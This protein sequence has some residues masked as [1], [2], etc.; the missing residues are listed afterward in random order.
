MERAKFK[1]FS[2]LYLDNPVVLYCVPMVEPRRLYLK[3]SS[4]HQHQGGVGV[5]THTHTLP[6]CIQKMKLGRETEKEISEV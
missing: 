3:F 5:D 2:C 6:R 1:H 4:Q